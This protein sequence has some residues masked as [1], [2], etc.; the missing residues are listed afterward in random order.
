[1]SMVQRLLGQ[2]DVVITSTSDGSSMSASSSQQGPGR[3]L[4][5]LGSAGPGSNSYSEGTSYSESTSIQRQQLFDNNDFRRLN[6]DYALFL[7][8]IGDRAVDEAIQ[9]QPLYVK[10]LP[11]QTAAATA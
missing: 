7:G 4:A 2:V 3:I 11:Q 10:E 5:Q 1:M 6:T 9:M 8:N